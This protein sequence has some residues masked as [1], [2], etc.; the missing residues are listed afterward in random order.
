MS[1]NSEAMRRSLSGIG[2][3]SNGATSASPARQTGERLDG[4]A[5]ERAGDEVVEHD[6]DAAPARA[7][8][9]SR[10]ATA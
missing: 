7:V 5:G 9:A 3:G 10:S 1:S 4:G 6:P 2:A 8:R